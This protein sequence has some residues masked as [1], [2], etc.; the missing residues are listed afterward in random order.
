MQSSRRLACRGAHTFV[1][2]SSDLLLLY[3]SSHNKRRVPVRSQIRVHPQN[4]QRLHTVQPGQ[5]ANSSLRYPSPALIIPKYDVHHK[6]ELQVFS[7]ETPKKAKTKRKLAKTGR[8]T[9]GQISHSHHPNL[10][11]VVHTIHI[12][13]GRV[14]HNKAC[15]DALYVDM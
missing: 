6:P 1:G 2:S 7:A 13:L 9:L 4:T 5:S 15:I 8:W 14:P 12:L 10:I 11:F 3:F